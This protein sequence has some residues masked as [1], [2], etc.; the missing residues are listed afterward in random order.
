MKHITVRT[1]SSVGRYKSDRVPWLDVWLTFHDRRRTWRWAPCLCGNLS[2]IRDAE[3]SESL[4]EKFP[5]DAWWAD[6]L[7]RMKWAMRS[8]SLNGIA[9]DNSTSVEMPDIYTREDLVNR[10][11]AE[12]LLSHWLRDSMGIAGPLKFHWKPPRHI[13]RA[14]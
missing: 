7:A 4:F 1:S 12:R 5:D 6:D 3:I 8:V 9:V 14:I 10:A 2:L 11:E 13:V